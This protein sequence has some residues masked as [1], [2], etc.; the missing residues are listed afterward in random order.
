[1]TSDYDAGPAALDWQH[2]E[3]IRLRAAIVEA[4]EQLAKGRTLWNGPCH[5]C[6]AVLKRA[7]EVEE[8][9]P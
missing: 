4:R 6:D 9:P 3:I 5:Q 8:L 7:L 1:M 2:K